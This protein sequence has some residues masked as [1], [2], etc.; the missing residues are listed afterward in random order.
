MGT[1]PVD[2]TEDTFKGTS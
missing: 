2:S 1:V